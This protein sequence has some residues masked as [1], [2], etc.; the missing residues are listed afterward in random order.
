MKIN[1]NMNLNDLSERMGDSATVAEAII[2]RDLLIEAGHDDS[3][4]ASV[5]EDEW[6][7]LCSR[8]AR[9]AGEA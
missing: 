5:A 7:L 9:M 8:A 6:L 2:M 1:E 3:D 4:S